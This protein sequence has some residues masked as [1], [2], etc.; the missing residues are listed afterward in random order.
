[1]EMHTYSVR[2]GADRDGSVTGWDQVRPDGLRE[3]DLD[4]GEDGQRDG[5]GGD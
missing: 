2:S 5:H 3:G 1:M 4:D